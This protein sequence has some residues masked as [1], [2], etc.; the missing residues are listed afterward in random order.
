MVKKEI[1]MQQPVCDPYE[2]AP[3]YE[4]PSFLLRLVQP[5]DAEDLLA[6]YAD[7][8]SAQYF[9]SDNCTSNFVFLTVDEMSRCISFWLRE[10]ATRAYIRFSIL[11]RETQKAIGTVEMFA[12]QGPHSI[13]HT[14]GVLRIDLASKYE[15][16]KYI[17]EL[18]HLATSSFFQAFHVDAILTKAVPCD[19]QRLS[20]LSKCS[21]FLV[22]DKSVLPYSDYYICC[23]RP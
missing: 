20:A 9:N 13:Y 5:G 14:V 11:S 18:L 7:P 15:Q 21:F 12:R 23:A 2:V 22:P 1:P 16:E 8:Q 17:S 3:A 4:T 6:C 19:A 10:Y